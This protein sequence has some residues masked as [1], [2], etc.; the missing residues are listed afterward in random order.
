[1]RLDCLPVGVMEPQVCDGK[2]GP[3]AACRRGHEGGDPAVGAS[4][5]DEDTP[6]ALGGGRPGGGRPGRR[7]GGFGR[8]FA[9]GRGQAFP[10][11]APA[12]L[13]GQASPSPGRW[14][15]RSCW[16]L[17]GTVMATQGGGFPAVAVSRG[18]AL[19]RN[20]LVPVSPLFATLPPWLSAP[21]CSVSQ[22]CNGR[23]KIDTSVNDG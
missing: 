22:V 16:G 21:P 10:G 20:D 17:I 19:P 18:S 23:T 12:A 2:R 7:T 9:G 8:L 14:G 1:M 6:T 15:A 5:C 4:G 13:A 11:R 3:R